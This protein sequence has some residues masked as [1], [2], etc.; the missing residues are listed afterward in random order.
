VKFLAIGLDGSP[1][2]L[3]NGHWLHKESHPFLGDTEHFVSLDPYSFVLIHTS[4]Y[5]AKRAAMHWISTGERGKL[6]GFS[7]GSVDDWIDLRVPCLPNVEVDIAKLN[8]SAISDRFDGS[9][10]DLVG[11]LKPIFPTA[12]AALAVLCQGYVLAAA[13]D[14]AAISNEVEVVTGI[15][16]LAR[17]LGSEHFKLKFGGHSTEVASPK[18]WQDSIGQNWTEFADSFRRE[19]N[20]TLRGPIPKS[21]AWFLE[22]LPNEVAVDTSSVEQAYSDIQLRFP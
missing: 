16:R 8:W 6:V 9:A 20:V 13:A 17:E 22:E 2:L 19:W 12:V 1:Q 10:A 3:A 7:G 4:L 14:G 5:G 15:D 21:L 18:W 11:L